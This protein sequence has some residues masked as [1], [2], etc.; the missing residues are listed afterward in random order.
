MNELLELLNGGADAGALRDHLDGL[1]PAER[2]EGV[3]AL[4]PRA[5]ALLYERA[6]GQ[7]AGLEHFVPPER[8]PGEPVRHFGVNSL[9]LFRRFEKRFMR[10]EDGSTQ[11]WGYNHQSLR[12]LTGPGYFVIDPPQDGEEA[13][14]DYLRVP[15]RQ[16]GAGW[17]PLAENRCH[18]GGLAGGLVYGG[19]VDRMRR[20][21]EHVSVGRA[22][23]NDRPMKAWFALVREC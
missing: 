23:K 9:P 19:M 21:S 8:S 20:V 7:P 22:H 12:P 14:I 4:P 15:P 11:V 2:S 1:S 13:A 10:A 3:R 17:P 16:P 18:P 6:A 5:L